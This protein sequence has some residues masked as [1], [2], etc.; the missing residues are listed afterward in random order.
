MIHIFKLTEEQKR[1]LEETFF[2]M[3]YDDDDFDRKD[4]YHEVEIKSKMR[5]V[6]NK[7]KL[8]FQV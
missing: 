8:I 6:F 4:C 2:V 5:N 3:E 1:K 7:I